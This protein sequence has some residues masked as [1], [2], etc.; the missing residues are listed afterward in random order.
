MGTLGELTA[1]QRAAMVATVTAGALLF[2]SLTG[3]IV[4]LPAIQ[5]DFGIDSSTLHWVIVAALLPLCSVAVVSGR[6]GDVAGRRRV[7]LLGMVCYGVGS[8]LCALAPDG[9]F[10]VAARAVQGLG[11]ALAVPLALANLTAALPEERRG[12]AIGVQTAATTFFGIVVPFAVAV[13]VEFASWRWA[14]AANAL[15]AVG[16]VVLAVRHLDETRGP[17]GASMDVKGAVLIG[18]GLT[19]VVFACERATDWG[20]AAPRTLL[21]MATGLALLT[22]FVRVELRAPDPLLDL[23][24]LRSPAASGPMGALALVQCAALVLSVQLALYLQ[25]VLDLDALRTGLLLMVTCLGTVVLSPF[26]GRL[27]DRGHGGRLVLGGLALLGACLIWLTYGV[28]HRH[29]A[30]LVP[31]LLAVGFAPPLVYTPATTL[32]L[33]AVPGTAR[34]VAASLSVQS[35]QIGGTLGLAL[36]N[37]LFTTVEWRERNGLLEESD[38]PLTAEE[39][40]ALDDALSQ[41]H[42]RD[43]VLARL[44]ETSRG[45]VGDAADDAFVTALS[46]GFLVLGGLLLLAAL[47]AAAVRLSR[48]GGGVRARGHRPFRRPPRPSRR[49]DRASR[50]GAPAAAGR[51]RPAWP[52]RC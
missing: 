28:A 48:S 25:H 50:S 31:A 52:R 40:S 42:E 30:L 15:A 10:L 6:L 19:L 18:C 27:T 17:A 46:V 39:Q 35:R 34:G 16:V 12:W 1:R 44:P 5:R 29:G 36:M 49:A 47:T 32:L 13:L 8:A 37:L 21:P 23:R 43:E 3:L 22:A 41:E 45:R 11:V 2:S 26:V 4:A 38:A 33:S 24:P 7:F 9:V 20:F 14:F 51:R